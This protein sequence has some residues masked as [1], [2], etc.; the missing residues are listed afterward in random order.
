MDSERSMVMIVDDNISN[1][2]AAK[3]ALAESYEVFTAPSAA[4]MFDLLERN[5]P[6]LILLDIDMPEMGGFEAIKILKANPAT[7]DIPVIF[8]S[9]MDSSESVIEGLELGAVDYISKP[10]IPQL[11]QKRVE[12]HLTVEAQRL[13]LEEQAKK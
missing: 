13:Q 11:L 8:L 1:L 10:F 6:K 4:K 3:N 5:K 2:K 9:G 12:L 7:G